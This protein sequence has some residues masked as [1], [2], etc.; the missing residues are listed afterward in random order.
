[1]ELEKKLQQFPSGAQLLKN[2]DDGS[3]CSSSSSLGRSLHVSSHDVDPDV[4]KSWKS[5]CS[6]FSV[7]PL[8]M[9]AKPWMVE[10]DAFSDV[11]HADVMVRE[12]D[13]CQCSL[14]G[15]LDSLSLNLE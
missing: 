1:M 4:M 8:G 10:E 11:G 15:L 9:L 6:K 3:R 2:S 7:E 5:R 14:D 12:D 13:D